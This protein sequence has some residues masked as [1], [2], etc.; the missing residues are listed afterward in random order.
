MVAAAGG[1]HAL[2][3]EG[4]E[5]AKHLS[6]VHKA[7]VAV[8]QGLQDPPVAAPEEARHQGPPVFL[9]AQLLVLVQDQN[10]QQQQQENE[11][12]GDRP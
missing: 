9:P 5:Q 6:A 7:R 2:L 4:Q 11:Q 12:F 3:D 10:L 8:G 1:V